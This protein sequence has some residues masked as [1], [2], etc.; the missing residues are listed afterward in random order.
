MTFSLIYGIITVLIDFSLRVTATVTAA[1]SCGRLWFDHSFD[2][3]QLRTTWKQCLQEHQKASF[4]D[5]KAPK[6]LVNQAKNRSRFVWEHDVAGSNPVIP[7][8]NQPKTSF[9]RLV[10]GYFLLIL[11]KSSFFLDHMKPL[12]SVLFEEKYTHKNEGFEN[13]SRTFFS[14]STAPQNL[15]AERFVQPSFVMRSLLSF[16]SLRFRLSWF[17]S[18]RR[19]FPRIPLVSWRIRSWICVCR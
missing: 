6:S 17:L 2:H 11:H 5:T 18:A 14:L 16:S 4:S 1:L 8:K 7:T 9:F 12:F 13:F 3:L 10:F 15:R 19:A